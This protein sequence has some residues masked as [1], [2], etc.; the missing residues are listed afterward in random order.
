MINKKTLKG[1]E[2]LIADTNAED[3]FIPE[4]YNEEQK[5]M[6][7]TCREFVEKEVHPVI[8]QL[9]QHDRTLLRSLMK[10]AGELGLLGVSVPEEYDGFGL[11]FISSMLA[12]E[13]MGRSYSFAVAFSAH[14]GIGTLPILYYGTEEQK[15]KY[16][17]KL[18]RGEFVGAYCLTEPEAGSDANSGKSRAKLSED[19][20][21][22]ILNGV[23]MWISNGG[24]AEVLIVF[25]KIEN[26][27]NLSAFIVDSGTPGIMIGPEEDKMGIRGSST[28]QIFFND[29]Q[30]PVEN[31]LGDRDGGFKIALNILNLG[32]IKLGSA[33]VGGSKAIAEQALK[34]ANERK[35]FGKFI[36]GFTAIQYKLAEMAIR[37]FSSESLNYRA[38]S[39]ID[40]AIKSMVADGMDKNKAAL[41]AMRQ[42]SIECSISKVMCSECLDYVADEAVQIHGGMGYSAE[43]TVERGYRDS[44]INRIFEGTNEINR[45]V[46]VG[47]LLKRAFKGE[48]DLMK[49]AQEVAKE[50]MGIP[51]FSAP[52]EDYFEEKRK[53]IRNFKKAILMVSGAAIQKFMQTLDEEQEL[54]FNAANMLMYTYAVESTML[55]VE[56]LMKL[57]GENNIR[58]YKD[59]LDVFLYDSASKINKEGVDAV[60][61]FAEGDEQMAL[62]MGMKRYTKVQPVN[63]RL[64]R[65]RI[66][67]AL[68]SENKYCL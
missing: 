49:P 29:V 3:I 43:T 10:K 34:Y 68:I 28:V 48:L 61:S 5:M 30:V 25:A 12:A 46:I 27:K 32:R 63:V 55:R 44:R 51:D 18:S 53:A 57:K 65:R 7:A 54:L 9:D 6:A 24:I 66:A 38:T 35:Q 36:S 60:N 19:G 56:K 59:I 31:L 37:I 41:E 62:L 39:N 33:T 15:R 23:K 58:I 4:E 52:S 13:E 50:L 8:K 42:F 40:D 1:G 17:T 45:M 26:D 11:N 22:Y 47:E 2:F 20:K 64:A 16:V 14:T 21:Y 67:Q